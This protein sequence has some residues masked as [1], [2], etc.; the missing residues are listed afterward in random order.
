MLKVVAPRGHETVDFYPDCRDSK[1]ELDEAF[2]S[3]SSD[4]TPAGHR[5]LAEFLVRTH[6]RE[7]VS[8]AI[9]SPAAEATEQQNERGAEA[10]EQDLSPQGQLPA[11]GFLFEVEG[12][13]RGSAARG[14]SLALSAGF[15][16]GEN[17]P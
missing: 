2:Q 5:L 10:A 13:R 6:P 9:R 3:D 12:R 14:L 16:A 7:A 4:F 11:L 15:A 17:R 1:E 8:E